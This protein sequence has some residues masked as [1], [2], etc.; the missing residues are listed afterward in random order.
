ML[1][2]AIKHDRD[3]YPRNFGSVTV[4]R[5]NAIEGDPQG[6]ILAISAASEKRL[7]DVPHLDPFPASG[8]RGRKPAVFH[9]ESC[10]QSPERLSCNRT[11]SF[12]FQVLLRYQTRLGQRFRVR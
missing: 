7:A 2:Y 5:Q 4:T 9:V 12:S 1:A 8:A 11:T 3:R 6:F 10:V